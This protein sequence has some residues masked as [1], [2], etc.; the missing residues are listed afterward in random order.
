MTEKPMFP[1]PKLEPV[2]GGP[3]WALIVLFAG[4]ALLVVVGLVVM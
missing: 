3:S 1:M 2:P 4:A